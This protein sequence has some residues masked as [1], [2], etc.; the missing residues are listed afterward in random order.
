MSGQLALAAL[1]GACVAGGMAGVVVGLRRAPARLVDV[2]R[3]LDGAPIEER[4]EQETSADGLALRV[5]DLLRLPLLPGQER[6]LALRGVAREQ[7]MADKVVLALVGLLSPTVISTCAVLTLGVSLWLPGL[8]G[9]LGLVVGYFLPDLHLL[10]EGN[11][12]R[13]DAGEALLTFF[14]LVTLERLANRSAPQALA[15][16][17]QMSDVALFRHIRGVVERARLE[18]R[19]PYTDLRRLAEELGLPELSDIADVLRLD[20][21]GASLA[22]MLRERVNELRDAHLTRAKISAHA[23]SERMTIWMVLPAMIFGLIFLT[24]PLL[25]LMS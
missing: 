23:T 14:D 24:P 15:S 18:Q 13:E 11:Q 4:V 20:E 19:P 17:A 3:R 25:R 8:T 1:S 16:A 21:T 5:A 10:K 2:F 6:L 22:G 7:F 12:T 9:L